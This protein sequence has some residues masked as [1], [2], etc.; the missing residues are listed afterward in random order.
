MVDARLE[1]GYYVLSVPTPED[2]GVV[3]RKLVENGV[4]VT[5]M[6]E[7]DN[8]L[9]DLFEDNHPRGFATRKEGSAEN[10]N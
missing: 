9:Q 8:P 3:L 1:G 2:A 5:E 4:L 7:L 6:R 10:Q